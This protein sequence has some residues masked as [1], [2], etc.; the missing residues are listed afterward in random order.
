MR[1]HRRIVAGMSVLT[2]ALA[3]AAATPPETAWVRAMLSRM[4]LR[5]KVGQLFTTSVHGTD[6]NTPSRA[7]V[8]EFGVATPA[9]VVSRYHLGGV[10]YFDNS[11]V[12]NIDDPKQVATLS[13]GL[14]RAALASGAHIPLTISTDQEEGAVT[15]IGAP[16]TV[17]PGSMALGASRSTADARLAAEITGAELRAMGSTRTTPPTPT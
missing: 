7:N 11:H 2:V 3:A 14:Q 5:E 12:D 13:D 4:S 17:F 15:R 10:V 8:D 16:A 1:G 6:A 9:E